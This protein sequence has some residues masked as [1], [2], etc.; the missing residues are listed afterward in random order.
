MATVKEK[1][2]AAKAQKAE[3]TIE[4]IQLTENELGLIA[5]LDRRR[6]LVINEINY[7]AQRQLELGYRQKEAEK[8]YEQNL[9]LEK[10]IISSLQSKYGNGKINAG[11]GLY[12]P[13]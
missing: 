12:I 6:T 8:L 1:K 9:E 2:E 11:L 3:E 13:V 10:Q 5:N 4:G 7:I